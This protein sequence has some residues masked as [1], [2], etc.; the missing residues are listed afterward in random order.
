MSQRERRRTLSVNPAR[1]H[2]PQAQP[3]TTAWR[4][5]LANIGPTCRDLLHSQRV[6]YDVHRCLIVGTEIEFMCEGID[7]FLFFLRPFFLVTM[8][9]EFL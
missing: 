2:Q 9:H 8:K 7:F 6:T 5:A 1:E 4:A 3:E